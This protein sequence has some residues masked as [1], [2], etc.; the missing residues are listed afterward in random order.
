MEF[1]IDRR[2]DSCPRVPLESEIIVEF[3]GL[4]EPIVADC[5]DLSTAGIALRSALLPD[6]GTAVFCSFEKV[7]ETA[8]F[9]AW[10]RVVWV[11]NQ[12]ERSSE[13]G[14]CF[15]NLDAEVESRISELLSQNALSTQ[16]TP[17]TNPQ[18]AAV[19]LL[20]DGSASPVEAHVIERSDDQVVFGQQLDLLRLKRGLLAYES[21]ENSYRGRIESVDLRL[22]GLLPHLYI[23]VIRDRVGYEQTVEQSTEHQ[24][25]AQASESED[26]HER[27]GDEVQ[28][29]PGSEPAFESQQR[30][31]NKPAPSRIDPPKRTDDQ[32][33]LFTLPEDNPNEE[34]LDS[35][36]YSE[37]YTPSSPLAA[38]IGPLAAFGSLLWVSLRR[39][40][41][42]LVD[43]VKKWTRENGTRLI[44]RTNHRIRHALIPSI[45]RFAQKL[46]ALRF[47]KRKRRTTAARS[48]L[49][50]STGKSNRYGERRQWQRLVRPLVLPG[51]AVFGIALAVYGFN[52]WTDSGRVPL[53]RP[54][55]IDRA[56]QQRFETRTGPSSAESPADDSQN[57]TTTVESEFDPSASSNLAATKRVGDKHGIASSEQ[58]ARMTAD[59]PSSLVSTTPTN[60]QLVKPSGIESA[61]KALGKSAFGSQTRV[62]GRS[63]TLRM[64]NEITELRGIPDKGGFTVII[65][66]SLSFDRAG[67]I[68]AAHPLVARSAIVNKGDH[69]ALTVRF[70]QGK[71]PAYRVIAKGSSLEITIAEKS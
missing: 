49:T 46:I 25:R 40:F 1:F 22:D 66:G 47:L 68:A 26:E 70:T 60:Y 24:V 50:A 23:T 21:H 27:Y 7:V 3:E 65:P 41:F 38:G 6:E 64:S 37:Q 54:V 52:P 71:S 34:P 69:S 61:E 51:L 56:D 42:W 2:S 57:P 13:F 15:Q 55:K 31:E 8:D 39:L 19:K 10:G 62:S 48:P 63:Y 67:P 33:T 16:S 44:S 17:E 9:G 36:L 14:V 29:N 58:E 45:T 59:R 28:W 30:I 53:H 12:G 32:C 4:S 5:V 35:D 20:F 11:Q 18:T 43:R